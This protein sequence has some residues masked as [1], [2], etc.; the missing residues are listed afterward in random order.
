MKLRFALVLLLVAS[1]GCRD[2]IAP[3][4]PRPSLAIDLSAPF[5]VLF[6]YPYARAAGGIQWT[7]FRV[8]TRFRGVTLDGTGDCFSPTGVWHIQRAAGRASAAPTA[9][10]LRFS[11]VIGLPDSLPAG[12]DLSEFI[13]FS[14]G[15]CA[16]NG[17]LWTIATFFPPAP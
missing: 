4:P 17:E 12:T 5:D 7:S 14:R 2:T 6:E 15:P 16:I 11:G 3:P 13:A 8:T 10:Q 9:E 1:L